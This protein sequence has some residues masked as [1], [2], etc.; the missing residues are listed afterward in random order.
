MTDQTVWENMLSATKFCLKWDVADFSNFNKN[1]MKQKLLK[2]PLVLGS[3]RKK[4]KKFT[5]RSSSWILTYLLNIFKSKW[6][7]TKTYDSAYMCWSLAVLSDVF[8]TTQPGLR[9]FCDLLNPLPLLSSAVIVALHGVSSVHWSSL[10]WTEQRGVHF[11]WRCGFLFFCSGTIT[12]EAL[13]VL[14]Q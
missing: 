7:L 8:L 13:E 5:K 10:K 11:E 9:W 12:W 3:F 6:I 4:V 14:S 1:G 2:S